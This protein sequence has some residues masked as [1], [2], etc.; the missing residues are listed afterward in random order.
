MIKN[1]IPLKMNDKIKAK[2]KS[3]E[4]ILTEKRH[5]KN[6]VWTSFREIKD[7][8]ST[9]DNRVWVG[10]GS[11]YNIFGLRPGRVKF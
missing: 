2:L 9:D 8:G 6:E 3:G 1:Y 4:Y 11:T 7:A 10:S 5:A